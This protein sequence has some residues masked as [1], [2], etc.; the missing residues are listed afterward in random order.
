MGVLTNHPVTTLAAAVV[1][2]L[3]CALNLFLLAQTF[4]LA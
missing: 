2:A 3:I 4:G 1:A